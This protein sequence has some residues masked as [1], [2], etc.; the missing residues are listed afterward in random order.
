MQAKPLVAWGMG[1]EEMADT[2]GMGA[3]T[4]QEKRRADTAA[5]GS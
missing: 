5:W 4:G 1:A 3:F 2:R